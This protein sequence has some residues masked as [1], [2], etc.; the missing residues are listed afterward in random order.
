MPTVELQSVGAHSFGVCLLLIELTDGKCSA[1]LLKAGLYHDVAEAKVGDTPSPTL[2]DFPD[3][4][5]AYK[6]AEAQIEATY[7]LDVEL[8][9]DEKRLLK[10]ADRVELAFF[11]LEEV[12]R[13]NHSALPMVGRILDAIG[14]DRLLDD[15]KPVEH[16]IMALVIK[17]YE[18]ARGL[19]RR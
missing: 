5:R 4:R 11:A 18:I 9:D 10:L 14:S 6:E 12:S 19:V 16:E 2:R 17:R 13:G 8:T 1:N 15:G 7:C 3:L